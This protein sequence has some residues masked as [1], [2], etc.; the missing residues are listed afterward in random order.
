MARSLEERATSLLGRDDTWCQVQ[1]RDG[2]GS[3]TKFVVRVPPEM[4]RLIDDRVGF[5]V[6]DG[7]RSRQ[8]L[9]IAAMR[10]YFEAVD[11]ENHIDDEP[12]GGI[13]VAHINRRRLM[14]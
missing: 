11:P 9:F 3:W 8:E 1:G 13:D 5:N 10:L 12:L 2:D 7:P 4:V 6:S 14:T